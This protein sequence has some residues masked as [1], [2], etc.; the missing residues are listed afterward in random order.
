MTVGMLIPDSF[1]L[2]RKH[3]EAL[4]NAASSGPMTLI[5]SSLQPEEAR[6]KQQ[7][8]WPPCFPFSRC[9]FWRKTSPQ[10]M[11]PYLLEETSPTYGVYRLG[12]PYGIPHWAG[13][14]GLTLLSCI[15]HDELLVVPHRSKNI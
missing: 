4:W 7:E 10:I 15:P 6:S 14:A 2:P 8:K 12:P 3:R 11:S 13:W 5:K 9:M 1:T